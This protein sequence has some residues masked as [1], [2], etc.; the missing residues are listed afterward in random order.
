[1]AEEYHTKDGNPPA[2]WPERRGV[3]RRQ[4][5]E[6]AKES[7]PTIDLAYRLCGPGGLQKV[8]DRWVGRCPLP[9][10]RSV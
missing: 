8:G 9:A 4:V 3:S 6:A 7:L 1:M 10:W 5:I 2:D